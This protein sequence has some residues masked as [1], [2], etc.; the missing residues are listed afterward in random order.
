M[1]DIDYYEGSP[2][3]FGQYQYMTLAN[4]VANFIAMQTEG[5]PVLNIPR[6]KVLLQA[7]RAFR[8]LYFDVTK[9]IK[10]I[11]LEVSPTMTV[12]LPPDFVNYVRISWVGQHGDLY[13]MAENRKMNIADE[14][15]QDQDYNLLFD[16]NGCVLKGDGNWQAENVAKEP[17][18]EITEQ[19]D[20][21]RYS[22]SNFQP[23]KNHVNQYPNGQFKVDSARGIIRFGS[24]V[25]SQL[26]V[27]EY[28][29][30]GLW[31][32]CEGL[33]ESGLRIHKFC[34]SAVYNYIYK[35]LI[36]FN[37]NVPD[38]EKRRAEKKW[39]NERRLAK[40]RMSKLTYDNLLQ[41]F[42]GSNKWVKGV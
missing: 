31:T 37:M 1:P 2:D 13:P 38:Y 35:E 8:E 21:Y 22:V 30:D 17:I 5:S 7:R 40:R 6:Y 12:T 20:F 11:E 25:E 26:I 3:N 42:K 36:S 16:D 9:E 29:S 34:E 32:G 41:I 14:Y 24:E 39:F 33:P 23:N 27:L 18:S 28:I 15:L 10:A 19:R 4:L